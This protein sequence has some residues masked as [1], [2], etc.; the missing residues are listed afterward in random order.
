M[1]T[2]WSCVI[3]GVVFGCIISFGE[4]RKIGVIVFCGMMGAFLGFLVS[5]AGGIFVKK[6]IVVEKY[7]I[8]PMFFEGKPIAALMEE[9]EGIWVESDN[10]IF[11]VKRDDKIKFIKH[12][13]KKEEVF[14]NLNEDEERY[15]KVKIS[16]TC[17]RRMWLWFFCGE[18]GIVKSEAVLR[19]GD[20]FLTLPF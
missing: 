14:F 9:H 17:K 3:F 5:F 18:T 12:C 2:F 8:Q 15:L 13:L 19:K 7:F 4:K 11:Q 10:Y 1:V 16:K 6:E 20:K